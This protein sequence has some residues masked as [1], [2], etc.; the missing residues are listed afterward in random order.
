MTTLRNIVNSN[1]AMRF[2]IE[3][4]ELCTVAGRQLLL[5]Q[6]MICNPDDLKLE[7][8][9]LSGIEK[10][11]RQEKYIETIE[12][13][14]QSMIRLHD[15]HGTI[16]NLGKAV[17]LDDIGLFEIKQFSL[18]SETIRQNLTFCQCDI[19]QLPDLQ[20]VISALDPDNQQLPQFYIYSSYSTELAQL[21]KRQQSLLNEDPPQAAMLRQQCLAVEDTIRQQLSLQLFDHV[22]DLQL[23]HENLAKLD[24]LFA[25]V[26][27]AVKMDLVL[28]EIAETTTVYSGLFNPLI[29][30]ILRQKNKDF[31]PV[32]ISLE[33]S[34]C[35]ITGANMGGK[36]VLLKSIALAQYLFQ[37]GFYLPAKEA[38][39]VPVEEIYFSLE[40]N[41]SELSGLSSFAAEM[42]NINKI[43]QSVR[44]GKHILALV[45]EPARTTNPDEG[46]ALVYALLGLLEK[47]AVRSLITT[48]YSNINV[49]CRKLIVKGLQ[50]SNLNEK[51]T[52]Q[53]INNFMDYSLQEHT[54][55]IVPHEA[56]RIAAILD[57]DQELLEQATIFLKK[58]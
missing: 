31:Q 28:P 40:D 19:Y 42:L 6:E 33:K 52:F 44:S 21:R 41:Q 23:A 47:S 25:K 45:D 39:V 56:L 48:H 37:F 57:V 54:S 11:V 8:E 12:V 20:E 1:T 36:T 22:A 46:R 35:L 17:V 14:R 7:F 53:N 24:I 50:I 5:S 13:I 32:D 58:N 27:Q 30:H 2:M 38:S 55:D 18:L 10:I 29:K 9:R 16:F 49:A 15:I 51:V 26:L 34:P 4:L 3:D 43:L